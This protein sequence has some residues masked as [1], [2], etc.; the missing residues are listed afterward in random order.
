MAESSYAYREGHTSPYHRISNDVWNLLNKTEERIIISLIPEHV[1]RIQEIFD[2]VAKAKRKVVLMGKKLQSL[3]SY[4]SES[5]Y[6]HFNPYTV[7]TL[8][9]VS[10]SAPV[11]GA[12]FGSLVGDTGISGIK[13]EGGTYENY[14]CIRE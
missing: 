8:P 6:L 4:A 10:F 2:N 12:A 11:P 14:I 13:F 5:N 1:Y 9:P 7:G 3:V